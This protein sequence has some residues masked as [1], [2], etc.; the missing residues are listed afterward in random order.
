MNTFKQAAIKILKK[1]KNPLHYSEITRL[2]LEK[3]ILETSGETPELTMNAL[4]SSDIKHKKQAS[5]FIRVKPGIFTLNKDKKI[6]EFSPKLIERE[7]AEEEQIKIESS[8]VGKAG[9]HLVCSELLFRGFN[10]SIMF[11]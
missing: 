2:A 3:G 6:I 1:T 4:I 10:A 11:I 5:D 8:Y 7:K 9:E